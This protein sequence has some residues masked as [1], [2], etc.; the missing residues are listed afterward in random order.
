MGISDTKIESSR[1]TNAVYKFEN[2]GSSY[3]QKLIPGKKWRV[4]VIKWQISI[5]YTITSFDE[6][7]F[8]ISQ[9]IAQS[10]LEFQ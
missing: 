7:E 5:L 8:K 10:H 4:R 2:L 3:I 1:R 9:S 6:G